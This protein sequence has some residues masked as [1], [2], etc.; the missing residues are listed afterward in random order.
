MAKKKKLSISQRAKHAESKKKQH[1]PNVSAEDCLKDLQRV[2]KEHP[3]IALTRNFY[4]VH[5]KIHESTWTGHFG[6][7]TEFQ[8]KAGTLADSRHARNLQN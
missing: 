4:R 6:T 1:D 2:A 3:H 7:W 5:G 8:R